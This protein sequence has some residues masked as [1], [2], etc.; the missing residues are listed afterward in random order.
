M[1]VLPP[2]IWGDVD[3]LDIREL[4]DQMLRTD[5]ADVSDQ[6]DALRHALYNFTKGRRSMRTWLT[7][8]YNKLDELAKLRSPVESEFVKRL[9]K[10]S[11]KDDKIYKDLLRDMRRNPQ[12][13]IP[14]LRVHL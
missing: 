6:V 1:T 13:D 4:Y 9:I 14:V 7:E 3:E 5:R 10:R 8:L 12:W 2:T 11:L